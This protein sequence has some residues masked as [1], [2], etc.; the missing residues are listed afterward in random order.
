MNPFQD[1]APVLIVDEHWEDTFLLQ[2]LIR[3]TKTGHPVQTASGAQQAIEWLR[4]CLSLGNPKPFLIFMDTGS[5]LNNGFDVLQWVRENADLK[6]VAVVMLSSS[7]DPAN[8]QRAHDLGAQ[9][10]LLKYPSSQTLAEV[11]ERAVHPSRLA[12]SFPEFQAL[13][14]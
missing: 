3:S 10:Y 7:E 14:S 9:G 2:R 11:I 5:P 6:D 8:L 12:L 4:L 13:I 1:R